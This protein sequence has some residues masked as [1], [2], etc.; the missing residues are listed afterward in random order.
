MND[1]PHEGPENT[2]SLTVFFVDPSFSLMNDELDNWSTDAKLKL[3]VGVV[4]VTVEQHTEGRLQDG[5]SILDLEMVRCNVVSA[6]SRT[7]PWNV[8]FVKDAFRQDERCGHWVW[9]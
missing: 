5:Q 2:C 4:S 9:Q 3:K 7:M 8:F 6:H 1:H